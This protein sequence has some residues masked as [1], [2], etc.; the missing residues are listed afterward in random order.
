MVLTRMRR[1]TGSAPEFSTRLRLARCG[2]ANFFVP[3][4]STAYS[5]SK[6]SCGQYLGP[7]AL[8]FAS[9]DNAVI[10]IEEG[11][12]L[13]AVARLKA[14]QKCRRSFLII[15]H[16]RRPPILALLHCWLADGLYAA[17]VS[18]ILGGNF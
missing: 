15:T 13:P 2:T 14:P 6:T 16:G 18:G 1:T 12:S 8:L 10:T 11:D 4:Y 17:S 3:Q 9:E 5:A 7:V